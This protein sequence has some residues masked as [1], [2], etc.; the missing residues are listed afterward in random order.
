MMQS[1]QL[2]SLEGTD[3]TTIIFPGQGNAGGYSA[4]T[5]SLV[6][7]MVSNEMG[8]LMTKQGRAFRVLA[9]SLT[10]DGVVIV[11]MQTHLTEAGRALRVTKVTQRINDPCL[12]I[13]CS[14]I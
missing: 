7:E 14:E 5:G 9:A 2:V 12:Q 8:V 11:E 13:V 1:G 6:E 10:A 4:S 3:G